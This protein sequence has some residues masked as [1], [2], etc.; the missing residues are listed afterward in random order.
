M[1]RDTVRR[2]TLSFVWFAN[3]VLAPLILGALVIAGGMALYRQ[4]IDFD[5]FLNYFVAVAI[6]FAF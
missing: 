4:G 1:S 3:W 2:F 6:S 5:N